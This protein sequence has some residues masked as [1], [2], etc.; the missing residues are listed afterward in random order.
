MGSP[1]IPR[2]TYRLQLHAGFTFADVLAIVPYLDRLGISHLYLSPFLKARAGSRHGYDIIDH[3]ALN[4]EIGDLA[5]LERLREALDLRGMGLV[6]DFVPNHMGV[7]GSD[8]AWWLDVLEWGEDSPY[9]R[10]FDI[11]WNPAR[12]EM[13]GKVLLPFLGDHYGAVLERGELVPRLDRQEGTISVWYWE[14]RYPVAVRGYAALLEPAA[15]ALGETPDGD[16]LADMVLDF[17]SFARSRAAGRS[18]SARRS[19]AAELKARLAGLAT[20]RPAVGQAVD[21]A[22]SVFAPDGLHA[23]L[24]RQSYRVSYWRVAADEINYRRFF[25]IND[26]AALRMIEE[27]D[28]FDR[29]HRCTLELIRRGLVDGLRIDHVD[30][31]FNPAEYCRRLQARAGEALGRPAGDPDD[32]P[33]YLLVEK[34]LAHHEPLR[35]DWPVAGT[36]GYEFMNQAVGVLVDGE[37]EDSLTATHAAFTGLGLDFEQ[38]VTEAKR[39]IIDEHMAAELRVLAVRLG[40]IASSHWRSADFTLSVLYTALKEVVA[41]LPVYRTYVTSRRVTDNDRRYIDWAVAKARKAPGADPAVFDFLAG[42]LTTDLARE[43]GAPYGRRAVIDFAMRVQQYT[44]PV[45]AKGFEDT[46]LYRYN[47]LI[48]LNE[49]GGDPRRFGLSP[50]AFHQAMRSRARTHSH[51]LLATA[52]HD[53]KRGE[54]TRARIAVLSELPE[55]WR[56]HV[57]RW[58][59]LNAPFRKQL[60]AGPAPEPNDEFLLYQTMLGAWPGDGVDGFVDGFVERLLPAAVKSVKEAKRR[61]SWAHPDEDY[62]QAVADFLRRICETDRKNPFLDDFHAFRRR[63]DGPGMLNG[64]VQTALKLTVPGVPDIYQGAELWDR[65][66]VDPDNR[67]PVDYGLRGRLM[68]G[69]ADSPLPAEVSR[70]RDGAVKQEMIRR[71]LDLRRRR[72]Q[73]FAA[74]AYRPLPVRGGRAANV[75]AFA[76]QHGEALV[77]VAVPLKT[78]RLWPEGQEVPPLGRAW[79]GVVVEAPRR[80][81]GGFRDL[82]TGAEAAPAQRRGTPVFHGPNLFARFP[83]AVLESGGM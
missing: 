27:P 14:H 62:E 61:T 11:D 29:A 68:G 9:A 32:Q 69:L 18:I 46:A 34:I 16:A 13:K 63:M 41:C 75:L 73:L 31:L 80:A 1:A 44:G 51:T 40:R 20:A 60:D 77:V 7:G 25:D 49:V 39:R 79:R 50:A 10:F 35:R 19:Q 74:G 38:E 81:D 12:R 23:L 28:L 22:L 47:R 17:R 71:L 4:P 37:G 82:M 67:R 45:M 24:E 76:R 54:D 78:A 26:L 70:W 43:E 56:S 72:P 3:N 53:S 57:E 66:L 59:Q 15:R 33:L 30:G 21:A 55:E 6:M 83:I 2:A 52:T 58:G 64:L 48:A 8:N 5:A 65:S 36:T 42:V